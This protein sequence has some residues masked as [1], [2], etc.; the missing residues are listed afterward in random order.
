MNLEPIIT[1]K[2]LN[3]AKEGAYTFKVGKGLNKH[4]IKALI[5]KVFDVHVVSVKT[6]NVV[7]EIKRTY[8]G[9]KKEIKP[10][11]KAVVRLKDKEE[12]ALF[13]ESKK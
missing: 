8:L 12:I 10:I 2:T 9:K 5:E 11:K 1:E 3:A 4:Q 7:G 13:E 6:M